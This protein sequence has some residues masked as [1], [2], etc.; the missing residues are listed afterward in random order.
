MIDQEFGEIKVIL[1]PEKLKAKVMESLHELSSHHGTEKTLALVRKRCFWPYMTADVQ[2][3]IDRCERCMLA[4]AP[5][6]KVKPPIASLTASRPF[7]IV[8]IDFTLLEKSSDGMENILVITDVFQ[9]HPG[10]TNQG[11][12]SEH[13]SKSPSERVVS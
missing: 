12:E 13:S 10:S 2:K 5:L 4:K 6:P 7:K 11:L 8:A 3:W 1:L 9:I